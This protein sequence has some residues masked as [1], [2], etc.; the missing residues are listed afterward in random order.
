MKTSVS[1]AEG[2]PAARRFCL[3]SGLEPQKKK[4]WHISRHKQTHFYKPSIMALPSKNPCIA[5]GSQLEST[6]FRAS[7]CLEGVGWGCSHGKVGL[8]G[9]FLVLC[10]WEAR[11]RYFFSY[12]MLMLLA[13][14]LLEVRKGRIKPN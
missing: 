3:P 6:P 10:M 12:Q 14:S 11:A 4:P 2:M 9:N 8:L 7:G 1:E 5:C 13:C